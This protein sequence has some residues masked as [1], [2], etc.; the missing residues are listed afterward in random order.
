VTGPADDTRRHAGTNGGMSREEALALAIRW[1]GVG[2]PAFPIAIS[3][4]VDKQA[5]DKAPLT[6]H[7]FH[8]A[9][10]DVAQLRRQFDAA[11][12]APGACLGVGLHLGPRGWMA[13]DVDVKGGARGDEEL[14]AL[15]EVH[16][17]LP[18]TPWATTASG[19]SH[20][21]LDK[22]D[23]HVDNTDLVAD[24]I[25]VRSDN[26]F[27]VAP[28]VYTPWGRWDFDDDTGDVLTGAPV[29]AAPLWIFTIL[30]A[31]GAGSRNGRGDHWRSVD[32]DRLHPADRAALEAL[33]RLGGHG[34]FLSV[35]QHDGVCDE[36][37][38]ITRPGKRSGT[39]ATIG[40]SSPGAVKVFTGNWALFEPNTAGPRLRGN[41]TYDADHLLDIATA[42]EAGDWDEAGRLAD[43]LHWVGSEDR[44]AAAAAPPGEDSD[45][46]PP[47]PQW[48]DRFD[49]PAPPDQA[50]Y[51]GLAGDVVRLLGPHT[52][53]DA[54]AILGQFLCAF[55]NAVGRG[56]YFQVG[57]DRHRASLYIGVV[58]ASGKGRKG[59]GLAVALLPLD[60]A[61][62]GWSK[63]AKAFGLS[64]GQGIIHRLRDP[65]R[66]AK[67]DV[68]DEGARDKRLLAIETEFSRVLRQGAQDGSILSMV[69]RQGWDSQT[70]QTLSKGSPERAG[71]AHLSMI[72][73]TTT[74]DLRRSLDDVDVLN[75]FANRF[76]WLASQRSRTLPGGG[77]I[78]PE[79]ARDLTRR[80]RKALEGARH[81]GHMQRDARAGA[82]WEEA[83]NVLTGDRTGALGAVCGRADAQVLR[84]SMVYALIDGS[85]VIREGHLLAALAFWEYAERS[86]LWIFGWSTGNRQADVVL[87]ELRASYPSSVT[88][89]RIR[90]LLG[91]NYSVD[92][93]L[94]ILE[95]QHLATKEIVRDGTRGRPAQ[96]WKANPTPPPVGITAYFSTL[97][98][99][100]TGG[101]NAQA[102]YENAQSGGETGN[103]A[104]RDMQKN[105]VNRVREEAGSPAEPAETTEPHQPEVCAD[106]GARPVHLHEFHTGR[107]L[108]L[109]C[110]HRVGSPPPPP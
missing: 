49:L 69:L 47:E 93:P 71:D 17:R 57:G 61:D 13:L 95:E 5:T 4:D 3:W 6:S 86:A 32:P 108:C 41:H 67:G 37:I 66:N 110:V 109:A 105:A 79:V 75:G 90:N 87:A 83:Y 55:G 70:L 42:V 24:Q 62:P 26:G 58:G 21:W 98:S 63:D 84:L 39:S 74:A 104:Y 16:G 54:A 65:Q 12:P 91:R 50:A 14:A 9:T 46:E 45:E 34:E 60:E 51:Y 23:R 73:H 40:Y 81:V 20:V 48:Q 44:P 8:D 31:G 7:G 96:H 64:T 94:T 28:G 43:P 97:K 11:A 92:E 2:V 85:D 53:G 52:E 19:G 78:S 88:R 10:T 100:Q 76:A 1:A 35:G 56:P 29:A 30:T 107:P 68:T 77:C 22:G 106:C 102:G 82:L 103:G 99:A 25:E 27:V 72:A 38:R 18:A 89:D 36:T 33:K 59:S 80:T 15:E 101:E